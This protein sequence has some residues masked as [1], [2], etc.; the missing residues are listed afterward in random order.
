MARH[1]GMACLL[2]RSPAA[3][4]PLERVCSAAP[5]ADLM[6]SGGLL[7]SACFWL[8][9]AALAAGFP[10]SVP[11]GIAIIACGY[12]ALALFDQRLMRRVPRAFGPDGVFH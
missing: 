11:S 5:L 10:P 2:G 8:R 3:A 6:L 1:F 7:Y 9:R 4:L 12:L